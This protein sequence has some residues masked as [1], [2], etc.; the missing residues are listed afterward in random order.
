LTMH[1]LDALTTRV[2]AVALQEPAPD[3]EALALI[4]RA[5]LAAP[6]H[7]RLRPWHFIL[8]RQQKRVDFGNVLARSLKARQPD[9]TDADMERERAKAM[10]APLIIAVVA[11]LKLVTKIPEIE[12]VVSAAAAAENML[13]ATHALGFGG[14]WKTGA[15]AYDQSVKEALGLA[16]NDHI[17]GFLYLG[18]L[19]RPLPARPEIDPAAFATEWAGTDGAKT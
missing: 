3:A 4:L 6:D 8:I 9:A 18:T 10:R 11:K 14:N 17:V 2:S 12:Q 7:G 13:V 1:A 5:G 16:A 19:A 15:P